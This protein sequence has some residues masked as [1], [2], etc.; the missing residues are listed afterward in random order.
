MPTGSGHA[1]TLWDVTSEISRRLI[2]LFL[3]EPDGRIPAHGNDPRFQSDPHWKDYLLFYEYYHA[4]NGCGLG[5][6]HQTG[7][8]GLVAK[9]IE[10]IGI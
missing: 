8:S 4:D 2:R 9:L 6:N 7:W 3:R 5:A 1:A 10:Q